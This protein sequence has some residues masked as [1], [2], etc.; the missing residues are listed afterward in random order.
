M[1]PGTDKPRFSDR[2]GVT[3]PRST[4]QIG[5][6]DDSLRNGIWNGLL[7]LLSRRNAWEILSRHIAVYM[8]KIPFDDLYSEYGS[9]AQGWVRDVYFGSIDSKPME[10]YD[11]YNLLE[12]IAD[13]I[14]AISSKH[15]SLDSYQKV[16]NDILTREMAGYRLM[17][18]HVV[19]ITD[20]V[21]IAA[22][23]S[24]INAADSLHLEGVS[25]HL[26]AA[27][28]LMSLKPEP[29]YRNSIKESISAVESV[30]KRISG[31]DHGGLRVALDSLNRKSP[32][33]SSMRQG[34]LQLYGYTSDQD[35][36]RHAIL[37]QPDIGFDEAKFMLVTCSAFVHFLMCKAEAAFLL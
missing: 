24:A 3:Q 32:I 10:W 34:F 20:E 13:N 30:V 17:Q 22:I 35:G 29:D 21:E 37:E 12:L 4:L 11:V 25:V 26:R 23:D 7:I 14:D 27:L 9:S 8:L 15:L 33:H 19:P 16:M 2:I 28:R 18:A 6:M 36:I 31:T 5:S 1:Q